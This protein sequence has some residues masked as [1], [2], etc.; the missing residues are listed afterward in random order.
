[1]PRP[2]R[3]ISVL[4]ACHPDRVTIGEAWASLENQQLPTGWALEWVVQ[5]DGAQ[6]VLRGLLPEDPRIRY[7]C[8]GVGAG[9]AATRNLGLARAQGELVRILDDDDQLLPG[10][11]AQ[12]TMTWE[13]SPDLGY[14]CSPA[15]DLLADG[16]REA[17]TSPVPFGRL[18]P[19]GLAPFWD[20]NSTDVPLHPATMCVPSVAARALGGWMALPLGEDVGLLMALAELWPGVHAP[21]PSML[22]RKWDAQLTA[23]PAC[24]DD[25]LTAARSEAVR[26]RVAAARLVFRPVPT[27][28]AGTTLRV[29]APA[30][31]VRPDSTTPTAG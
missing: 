30:G 20:G 21:G 17:R 1:M 4:T 16:T 14:I 29:Q 26:Q 25:R 10:A 5:E 12:D 8:N 23:Q 22:Y 7:A 6:A 15:I 11:L 31:L 2:N 28:A 13:E 3:L 27:V 9:V 18:E 19:G 24:R